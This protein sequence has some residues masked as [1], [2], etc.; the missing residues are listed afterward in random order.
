MNIFAGALSDRWNKKTMLIC[1]LIAAL[2]TVRMELRNIMSIL[3]FI[4]GIIIHSMI[5]PLH[6][7]NALFPNASIK[8]SV[9][10]RWN[11]KTMLICDLIAALS[12]VTVLVLVKT[13]SLQVK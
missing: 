1:D 3:A 4:N 11:K 9:F 12:T 6:Q 13:D 10:D 8:F 2:S 7:I 5:A